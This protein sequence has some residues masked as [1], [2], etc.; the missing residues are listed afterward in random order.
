MWARTKG[1]Y[2]S[3]LRISELLLLN[4]GI[5]TGDVK[6]RKLAWVIVF[7]FGVSGCGKNNA[8]SQNDTSAVSDNINDVAF[9]MIK[10]Q[11]GG[12]CERYENIKII[13]RTERTVGALKHKAY[14]IGYNYDCL[15]SNYGRS[16]TIDYIGFVDNPD[17]GIYECIHNF[18]AD[19]DAVMRV[20]WQECGGI[21]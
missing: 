1:A 11:M 2:K 10:K 7:A 13:D 20:G 21:N 17:K 16:N 19:K 12:T 18:G 15:S 4:I 6:M 9:S 14:I 8:E 5:T 3:L